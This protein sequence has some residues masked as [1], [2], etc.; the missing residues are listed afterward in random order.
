MKSSTIT[1]GDTALKVNS[2]EVENADLEALMALAIR[3]IDAQLFLCK[4]QL[5]SNDLPTPE[6]RNKAAIMRVESDME[7]LA[8]W[9]KIA[10]AIADVVE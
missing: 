4:V 3:E 6:K 2:I 8:L 10:L 5:H 9:R 1:R 7:A